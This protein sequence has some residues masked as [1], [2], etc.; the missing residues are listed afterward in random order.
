MKKQTDIRQVRL[1]LMREAARVAQLRAAAED[2]LYYLTPDMLAQ[3]P[4]LRDAA[5]KLLALCKEQHHEKI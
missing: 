5:D 1:E 4:H 2:V 3:H